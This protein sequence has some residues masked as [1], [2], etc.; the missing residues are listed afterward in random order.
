MDR[1]LSAIVLAAGEGT[2]MRSSR[3]KPLHLLCGRAMV[4]Y[5]LD[6]LVD[7]DVRRAVVVVG[8]GAE[9]VT[10]K[11]VDAA[12][13][14]PLEF[15]EQHVQRGTGDA[16]SVALTAFP[17]ED[18]DESDA[19]LL[20]LPGDTPL[21]RASTITALVE[22]HRASDAA[23]TMLTAHMADPTG[24]GRV[25][26]GRDDRVERVVEQA[27]ATDE[28]LAIDEVNTS[29]YCFRASLLAPALRRLSPENVQG[30][31]Y[32]TDVVGVLAAAGY[33]VAAVAAD[34]AADTQGVNDRVQLSTAEAELRRRTNEAWLRKGVTMLDPERTYVDATVELATDVT[35]FPGTMLQGRCVIGS[36]AEIGP[37]TRLVDCVVGAASVVEHTVGR[38]A[39]IGEGTVVG[40]FAALD[41]GSRVP[42]GVR[43]GPFYTATLADPAQ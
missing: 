43:T 13:H 10:K 7:C 35:L 33:Q 8:H 38:D 34:D 16:V 6:S 9:R 36:G 5:V 42:D 26:R 19:D 11:L 29:I 22:A 2:R 25:V 4:L 40:P 14:V 27:D 15:V 20:V 39:E 28:E 37:D 3:P 17:A 1:P 41:A 23:C 30:E 18:L 21:L 31:Y 12:P 32:L 24:Y